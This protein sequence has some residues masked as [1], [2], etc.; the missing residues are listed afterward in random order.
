MPSSAPETTPKS[1]FV[2]ASGG[3]GTMSCQRGMRRGAA[4][5]SLMALPGLL[6]RYSSPP[7]TDRKPG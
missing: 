6:L 1:P 5:S 2:F 3:G 7:F 4:R